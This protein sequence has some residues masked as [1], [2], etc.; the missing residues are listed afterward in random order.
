MSVWVVSP[1]YLCKW[2]VQVSVYCDWRIPAHLTCTQ[3]SILLHLMDICFLPCICLW[4]TLCVVI[5]PGL[6][7]HHSIL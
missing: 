7:R 5:G 1:D 6:S 4:Q 2:Q 3:Y